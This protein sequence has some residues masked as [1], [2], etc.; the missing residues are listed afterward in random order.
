MNEPVDV[1]ITKA[2]MPTHTYEPKYILKCVCRSN[3]FGPNVV[4]NIFFWHFFALHTNGKRY[5]Q[6][7]GILLVSLQMSSCVCIP[8]VKSCSSK[9][10]SG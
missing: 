8:H 6:P 3:Y 9:G 5:V 7:G 2:V 1:A 4:Q 10:L